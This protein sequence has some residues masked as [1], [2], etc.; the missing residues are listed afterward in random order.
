MGGVL[1]ESPTF[2]I[3]IWS[4]TLYD[5]HSHVGCTESSKGTHA[6]KDFV[7]TNHPLIVAIPD[8][9]WKWSYVPKIYGQKCNEMR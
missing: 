2:K 6:T 7:N 9:A 4:A 1:T 5:S 8:K 3:S